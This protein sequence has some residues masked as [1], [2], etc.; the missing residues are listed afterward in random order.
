MSIHLAQDDAEGFRCTEFHSGD[1][2]E[3]LA[4]TGQS[5]A[6]PGCAAGKLKISFDMVLPVTL[7]HLLLTLSTG[8]QL[9]P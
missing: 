2:V 6:P 4:R 5:Q 3:A 1:R 8:V 9:L 7:L